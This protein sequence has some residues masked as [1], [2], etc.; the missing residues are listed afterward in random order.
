MASAGVSTL[1]RPRKTSISA[2]A[3]G[4]RK[5]NSVT[6]T[7][8]DVTPV[9]RAQTLD[10]T[11]DAGGPPVASLSPMET[12]RSRYRRGG[13]SAAEKGSAARS[14]TVSRQHTAARADNRADPQ[15][16]SPM[17][18]HHNTYDGGLRPCR[19]HSP[20][21][22]VAHSGYKPASKRRYRLGR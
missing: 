9:D 1:R 2:A 12:P 15:E 5:C 8:C 19:R 10:L 21:A 20:I 22:T 13:P 11:S 17:S 16:P 14:R 4:L 6:V 7:S 3:L 18:R